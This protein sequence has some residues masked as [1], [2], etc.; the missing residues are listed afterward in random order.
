[1]GNI[2]AKPNPKYNIL[3]QI[4]NKLKP[5][6]YQKLIFFK[7][8]RNAMIFGL[9]NLNVDKK[10]S[11]LIPAYICSSFVQAIINNGYKVEYYDI[12]KDFSIDLD[13]LK[14]IIK[15]KKISVL[16]IVHYFGLLIDIKEIYK[17]CELKNIEIIEDYCHSFFSRVYKGE[18]NSLKTTKIYSIRK[19]LPIFDGG[20]IEIP[21]MK[22]NKNINHDLF[23][24]NDFVFLFIRSIELIINK[25]GFS[26]LYSSFYQNIKLKFIKFKTNCKKND[27][28]FLS[29]KVKR[30][31]FML[32]QYLKNDKYL[33]ESCKKRRENYNY[34]LKEIKKLGLHNNFNIS[35]K[36]SVPQFLPII[37]NFNN[38]LLFNFLNKNGIETIKWPDF[39]MP[40]KIL[41][42]KNKYPNSNFLNENVI[43]IPIHQSLSE[44]NCLRMI[45]VIKTFLNKSY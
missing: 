39:E 16:V 17:I 27:N 10:K 42:D 13:N 36:K 35:H 25:I 33:M 7:K 19:N 21:N 4:R 34:L 37:L 31:S 12:G 14:G 9:E 8:G 1:M 6:L 15:N 44:K 41:L 29:K 5:N 30:P 2:S 45:K 22:I 43:L 32:S 23:S 11:I 26:N 28:T 20:A 38:K 18:D 3:F 40:K 24:I